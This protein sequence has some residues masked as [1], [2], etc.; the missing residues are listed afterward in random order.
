MQLVEPDSQLEALLQESLGNMV[1]DLLEHPESEIFFL[2][3]PGEWKE[4]RLLQAVKPGFSSPEHSPEI[5]ENVNS[6]KAP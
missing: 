2:Y 4:V 6:E 5:R 1:L 3:T